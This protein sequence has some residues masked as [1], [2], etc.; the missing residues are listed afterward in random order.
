[1][2]V[3]YYFQNQYDEPES[4]HLSS[5]D[6]KRIE[7]RMR[8]RFERIS[9]VCS[10]YELDCKGE[11]PQHKIDPTRFFINEE[12]RIEWCA[13]PKAAT[14]SIFYIFNILAGYESQVL[15]KQQILPRQFARKKYPIPTEL[16][17]L[18]ALDDSVSLIIVRHPFERLLSAYRDKMQ[19][20]ETDSPYKALSK[21]IVKKFRKGNDSYSPEMPTFSEFV[22]YILKEDHAHHELCVHWRPIVDLCTPCQVNFNVIA[23]FET[24]DED[25]KYILETA[26]ISDI[27]SEQWRNVGKPMKRT[28]EEFYNELSEQQVSEL[29]ELY[30]SDFEIFDY[31]INN[32]IRN[33]TSAN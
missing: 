5:K 29:F 32:F 21:Y 17:I 1:M 19:N 4:G 25:Q 33:N 31:S 15:E 16:E 12:Y 23:K 28:I 7:D 26:N 10:K 6:M 14:T 27:I 2:D 24:L 30:K 13:V 22:N 20:P 11:D 8:Q 9:E 18:T 3:K